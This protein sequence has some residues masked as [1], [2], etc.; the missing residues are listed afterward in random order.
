M[1]NYQGIDRNSRAYLIYEIHILFIPNKLKFLKMKKILIAL[2]MIILYFPLAAN[3]SLKTVVAPSGLKLRAMPSLEGEVIGVL[4]HKAVV[5]IITNEQYI[6]KEDEI[7]YFRGS[8][9]YVQYEDLEGYVFDGLLTDLPVPDLEFEK[10][11]FDLE[12]I[13]PLEAWVDFHQNELPISDTIDNTLYSKLIHNYSSGLRLEKKST[14]HGFTLTVFIPNS[15]VSD[16]YFLLYNMLW[17]KEEQD[18]YN[19]NATFIKN[20]SGVV[21]KINIQLDDKIRIEENNNGVTIEI[22]SSQGVC[23]F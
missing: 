3:D 19:R 2:A 22:A 13:Y 12:L 7:N 9:V 14:V 10:T 23:V 4:P 11:Q 20:K 1:I 8:W 21:N 17:T 15:K 18:T 16:A 6:P 5:E